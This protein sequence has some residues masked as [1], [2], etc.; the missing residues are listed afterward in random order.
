[1]LNPVSH[2]APAHLALAC[3]VRPPEECSALGKSMLTIVWCLLALVVFAGCASTEVISSQPLVNEMLPRPTHIWIYDLA[4]TPADVP[5]DSAFADPSY[6]PSQPQ[7]SEEITAGR[8]AGARWRQR[9][10]SRSATWDCLRSA[11]PGKRGRRP[12]TL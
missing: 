1:M 12:T 8:Q 7:T 5:R 9:S 4:A 10:L 2:R 6:R 11:L 3:A